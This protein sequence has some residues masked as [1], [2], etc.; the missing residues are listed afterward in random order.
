MAKRRTQAQSRKANLKRARLIRSRLTNAKLREARL[1]KANL[2]AKEAAKLCRSFTAI[3]CQPTE[4]LPGTREKL[5]VM[6]SRIDA[7]E[8]LWNQDDGPER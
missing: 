1:K 4:L 7:G 6:A 8:E 5:D 2:N 3:P